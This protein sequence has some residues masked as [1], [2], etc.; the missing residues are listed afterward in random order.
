MW[1][2]FPKWPFDKFSTASRK[3]GTQMKATGEVMSICRTF[4]SA[5]LK[6][7][8]S[9]EIKCDGLHIPF[10]SSLDDEELVEKLACDDERIFC[11]AEVMRR[12]LMTSRIF[13][14]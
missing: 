7:L 1:S 2:K 13:T 11:I 9:M 8:T 5:L 6:A 10:V 3:L 4:E 12:K 14:I